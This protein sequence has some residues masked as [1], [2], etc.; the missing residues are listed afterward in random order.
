MRNGGSADAAQRLRGGRVIPSPGAKV[1]LFSD[2]LQRLPSVW[3]R[4]GHSK[5]TLANPPR[6]R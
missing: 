4:F 5:L 3:V 1:P 2:A 6:E